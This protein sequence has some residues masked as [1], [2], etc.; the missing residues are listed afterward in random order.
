MET[1][2][3]LFPG[4]ICYCPGSG[5]FPL[6]TDTMALGYFARLPKA[7][8]VADLGSGSGALGLLLCGSHPD[9]TVTGLEIQETAHQA[10]LENIARNRLEGR[11]KSVL[12]SVRDARQLFEA[13]SFSCVVSNPPYFPAGPGSSAARKELEGT[14]EDF[15]A[16]A[17]WLLQFGGTFFLVHRTERLAD[18]MVLGRKYGLEPKELRFL[19]HAPG[20]APGLVLLSCR[21]GAKMSLKL[22]PD[23]ILHGEDGSPTAEYRKIYHLD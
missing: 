11:M 14:L 17:G 5:T 3:E 7:A 22:L 13:G 20:S 21:K 15:F 2:Q 16:C 4:G 6:S 12:G 23:L 9:C 1:A 18:L 8:K 19:R 10:A